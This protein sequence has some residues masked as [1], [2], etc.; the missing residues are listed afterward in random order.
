[1][2]R[3]KRTDN[4]SVRRVQIKFTRERVRGRFYEVPDRQSYDTKL[5]SHLKCAALEQI[6]NREFARKSYSTVSKLVASRM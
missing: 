5:L 4:A 3:F 1:M 6:R 2:L